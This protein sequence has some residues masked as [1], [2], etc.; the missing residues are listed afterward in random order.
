MK[1]YTAQEQGRRN[2]QEENETRMRELHD[3]MER[4][5]Q[6][7]FRDAQVSARVEYEEQRELLASQKREREDTERKQKEEEGLLQLKL[8]LLNYDFHRIW[9]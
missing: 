8:E 3:E 4:E 5:P 9:R 6:Q 2:A 1:N 7:A